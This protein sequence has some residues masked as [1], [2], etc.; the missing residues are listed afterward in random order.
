M[1]LPKRRMY[2]G[3]GSLPAL[4]LTSTRRL[5]KPSTLAPDMRRLILIAVMLLSPPLASAQS[6]PPGAQTP[7]PIQDN[8]FLIEEA[9]NQE[10]GVV[11][12]INSFL[13]ARDGSWVYTFTQEWPLFGQR[14][15][16]S[17]TI[18]VVKVREL[19]GAATGIG[20]IAIN[21]RYQLVGSGES[22]VAVSPRFSILLPTGDVRQQLGGGGTGLQFNIPVSVVINKSL[23][24]HLNAG[25][26]FT[27]V[28][29]NASGEKA[30]TASYNLGQSF[31]W[32]T[33]PGFNVM[34]ETAWNSIE[35][36]AG[37]NATKRS[38]TLFISPGVRG[39]YNF[40]SGLQIVPGVG[41]PFGVGPTSGSRSVLVY[42]SFEHPVTKR[43]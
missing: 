15:Q 14:N 31:I 5:K 35:L 33:R 17:Y 26:T 19:P 2:C 40:K 27:P 36:V 37:P 7:R 16:L 9:Y 24:T 38:Q 4:R 3:S 29:T 11:Q 43:D 8:S 13:R 39:A 23:V 10:T 42:L 25:G 32:L 22:R 21:Y 34:L 12:H 41:F 1:L 18:P 6:Q 20:D 30:G 28:A